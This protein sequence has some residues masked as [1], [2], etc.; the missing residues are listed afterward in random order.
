MKK[1]LI[2][3]LAI[4]LIVCAFVGCNQNKDEKNTQTNT[5]VIMTPNGAPSMALAKMMKTNPTFGNGK[6]DYR[7]IEA[8]NVPAAFNNAEADFIIAPTNAGVQLSIKTDNYRLAAVTSWGN[9]YLVGVTDIKALSECA[10]AYEF[11]DQFEGK[12]VASIGTNA[13]PDVTFRHLLG[14]VEVNAEIGASNAQ[15]IQAGLKD[16]TIELTILGEPAVTATLTNVQNAKRLASIAD[17]WKALTDQDFPQAS[18]FV[19][20]SVIEEH[21]ADVDAFLDRVKDSINYLNASKENAKE[22]GD[23]MESLETANLKGAIVAKCYL[24]M[25]QKFVLA[26][27]VQSDVLDFVKVLGVNVTAE[28]LATVVYSK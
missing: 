9:L 4:T 6:G 3:I 13:V 1:F 25:S 27:D 24:E 15:S 28:K 5:Y 23:Y 18:L 20:K 26:S 12:T 16:N 21:K 14:I 19:K 7:I 22:L 8:T 10:D 2:C 17:L 11:L